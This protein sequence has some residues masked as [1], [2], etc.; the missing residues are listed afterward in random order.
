MRL[1]EAAQ[2]SIKLCAPF[3]KSDIVTDVLENKHRNVSF[4]LITKF[5]LKNFHR[6]SSDITAIEQTISS[7]GSVYNCSNLHSKIYIFDDSSCLITSANLTSSG[8]KR[9]EECGVLRNC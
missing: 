6:K 7:G 5:D 1:S 4:A 9:N 8:L 2:H 3:V